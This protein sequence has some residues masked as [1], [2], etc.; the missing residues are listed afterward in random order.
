V[1]YYAQNVETS[2]SK[3][4]RA[5]YAE[6]SYVYGVE[7]FIHV[8]TQSFK[9][10]LSCTELR[11]TAGHRQFLINCAVLQWYNPVELDLKFTVWTSVIA[12]GEHCILVYQKQDIL[13][14]FTNSDR[15]DLSSRGWSRGVDGK[16]SPTDSHFLIAYMCSLSCFH[17]TD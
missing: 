5:E 4:R 15:F 1:K 11:I 6:C 12:Y 7:T 3:N 13:V 10:W 9:T 2:C 16:A 14:V 8:A 17:N